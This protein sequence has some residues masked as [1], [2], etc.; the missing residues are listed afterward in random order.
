MKGAARVR[1]AEPSECSDT[2]EKTYKKLLTPAAPFIDAP[3]AK[4]QLVQ[5]TKKP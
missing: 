2:R 4:G 3:P 1:P 5:N